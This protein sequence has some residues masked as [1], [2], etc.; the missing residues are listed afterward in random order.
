MLRISSISEYE[1]SSR[2]PGPASDWDEVQGVNTIPATTT[3]TTTTTSAGQLSI[4]WSRL[5]SNGE[6]SLQVYTSLNG[7]PKIFHSSHKNIILHYA[8]HL[9]VQ[10]SGVTCTVL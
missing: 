5:S 7:A 1:P 4:S 2:Q 6:S 8:K 9:K 10:C 3:T